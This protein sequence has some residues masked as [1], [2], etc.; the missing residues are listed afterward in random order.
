MKVIH[1]AY[2][3]ELPLV[4]Y[5]VSSIIIAIGDFDGVHLGH[6]DVIG[7]AVRIGQQRGLPVA[8][9]TFHPH[10]REVLGKLTYSR[11]LS[12]LPEKLA[13][14][15][16][17]GVDYTFV[18]QFDDAFSK[19]SPI[20]FVQNVLMKL[21]VH[22]VVVGFDFTFGNQAEGTVETLKELSDDQMDVTVVKPYQLQGEKISSTLIRELLHL[23]R[24]P[25]YSLYT[26]RHYRITGRVIHGDGRGQTIGFPT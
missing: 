22:T 10:P 14:I 1:V 9:M 6:Q 21:D 3:L 23:G 7:Q 25:H 2:P 13:L 16:D 12:P 8:V 5:D 4:D 11:Y 19:V 26:G 20:D 24:L 18:V 15:E 17:L